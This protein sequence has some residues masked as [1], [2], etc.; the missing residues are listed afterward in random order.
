MNRRFGKGLTAG[1]QWTYGHSI[2]NTGGSNEAQTTQNPFN[3]EQDRGNNAFDVRHS[4]NVSALYQ[5]PFEGRST[6]MAQT[7]QTV[8]GGWE[9]GGVYNARTGL[10][11]DV[12]FSR[13]DIVYQVNGT[14]QF[15]NSPIV[16]DGT[17]HDHAVIDNPYGGAFRNNRR[18]MWL[19]AWTRSCSGRQALFPESGGVH[20]SR[21]RDIRQPGPLCAPRARPEPVGLHDAQAVP[22]T[23]AEHRIPGGNLQPLQP[24]EFRESAGASCRPSETR[25]TRFSPVSRILPGRRGRGLR[26]LQ[27][28]GQQGR[29]LGASGRFSC[30]CV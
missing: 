12:T 19:P 21:T 18:P 2:G 20:D 22:I 30:R 17:G 25:R 28:D 24:G 7:V 6:R 27:F 13:P 5:L 15:V 23:E 29:G 8:L 4:V 26:R 10:P 9:I 14:N 16:T 1:L 11:I 3:F